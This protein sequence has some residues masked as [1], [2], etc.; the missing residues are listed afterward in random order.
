MS[1]AYSD[2]GDTEGRYSETF[3]VDFH[4]TEKDKLVACG[5]IGLAL[6]NNGRA[7]WEYMTYTSRVWSYPIVSIYDIVFDKRNPDILY[8]ANMYTGLELDTDTM[9]V[10]RSADGRFT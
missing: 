10:V 7:T 1:W 9:K 4:P 6:S 5:H 2:L 8:G 3:R